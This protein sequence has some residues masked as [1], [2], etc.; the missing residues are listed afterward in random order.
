MVNLYTYLFC[1]SIAFINKPDIQQPI[2]FQEN[3]THKSLTF[4]MLHNAD[5][6]HWLKQRELDIVNKSN[7]NKKEIVATETDYTS[8]MLEQAS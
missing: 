6:Y 8:N 4:D 7:R 2:R 1:K 3:A 5:I